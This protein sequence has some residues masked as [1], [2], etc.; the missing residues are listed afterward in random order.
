MKNFESSSTH[1]DIDVDYKKILA[2]FA[3]QISQT[4][5]EQKEQESIPTFQYETQKEYNKA[6]KEYDQIKKWY[7]KYHGII[8]ENHEKFINQIEAW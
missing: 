8:N 1:E 7:S 6:I 4:Q 2:D 3:D 5:P